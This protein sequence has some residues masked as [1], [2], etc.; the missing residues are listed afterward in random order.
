MVGTRV[1]VGLLCTFTQVQIVSFF[2][3]IFSGFLQVLWNKQP[4]FLLYFR[5]GIAILREAGMRLSSRIVYQT[6][7]ID[8]F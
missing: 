3:Y 8:D 7:P 6:T 4:K 2:L 1:G 5:A